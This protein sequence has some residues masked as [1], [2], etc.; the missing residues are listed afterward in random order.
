MYIKTRF[1]LYKQRSVE[2]KLKDILEERRKKEKALSGGLP[3]N[4]NH[5]EQNDW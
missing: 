3:D 1:I 2:Q 5:N 4:P